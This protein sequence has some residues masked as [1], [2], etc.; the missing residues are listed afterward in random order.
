MGRRT[1]STLARAAALA[2]V[3]GTAA[4]TGA[5]ISSVRPEAK[6]PSDKFKITVRET[7]EKLEIPTSAEKFMLTLDERAAVENFGAEHVARGH[8]FVTIAL[9]GDEENT[10]EAAV[11]AAAEAR[12]I[13]YAQGIPY[14]DV[15]G[16]RYRSDNRP[17]EPIV[18]FFTA[19]EAEGPDCHREWRDFGITWSGDNTHNFGCASQANLAAMVADPRDLLGPRPDDA[20]DPLRR[21]Q[22][23]DKYRR[24][25]TTITDRAKAETAVVSSAID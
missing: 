13:L 4:C 12:D 21:A 24:G 14:E 3:A 20:P 22:V 5:T 9:P 6:L 17:D 15:R 23:L 10:T 19:Y 16:T 25:E 8:G 18:L 7:R 11:V 1:V 2:L